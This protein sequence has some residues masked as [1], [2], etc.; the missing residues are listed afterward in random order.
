MCG[1]FSCETLNFI[2]EIKGNG[3]IFFKKIWHDEQCHQ[4]AESERNFQEPA[5]ECANYVCLNTLLL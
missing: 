1:Y 3:I 4:M 5:V 2:E